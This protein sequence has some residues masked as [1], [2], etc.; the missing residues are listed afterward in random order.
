[1]TL[2]HWRSPPDGMS[3]CCPTLAHEVSLCI[4]IYVYIY[5]HTYKYIYIKRWA[6]VQ[7]MGAPTT[8]DDVAL[9]KLE[10]LHRV[11]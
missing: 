4:H 11:D 3:K 7:W 8:S 1:M 10:L 2:H 6:E 5:I 9:V